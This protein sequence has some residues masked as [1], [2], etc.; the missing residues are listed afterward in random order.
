[1]VG[2]GDLLVC[3]AGKRIETEGQSGR[4]TLYLRRRPAG[5]TTLCKRV[6]CKSGEHRVSRRE[7]QLRGPGRRVG[8]GLWGLPPPN[9]LF[10]QTAITRRRETIGTPR[11]LALQLLGAPTGTSNPAPIQPMGGREESR[12]P[13]PHWS[14]LLPPQPRIQSP[15]PAQSMLPLGGAGSRAPLARTPSACPS[16]PAEAGPAR[17]KVYRLRRSPAMRSSMRGQ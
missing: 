15:R 14:P 1:M 6:H 5:M 3:Y 16:S 12:P 2:R 7:G 8:F 9:L 10:S 17:G 4:A 13:L 11:G